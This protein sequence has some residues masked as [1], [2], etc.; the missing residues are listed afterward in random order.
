MPIRAE[1][2]SLYPK[3]WKAISLAIRNAANWR[4]EG[5]PDYPS[6][7]AQNGQ[8]HPETGSK[9]V[10]TV[11]HLDHHPPNV[12]RTNLRAWCQRCHLNYDRHRHVANAAWNRRKRLGT[13]DL[14]SK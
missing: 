12:D 8:P 9:V 13:A 2:K 5:S 6:C 7:R 10:L 1:N 14:F 3:D 4:C 11:A